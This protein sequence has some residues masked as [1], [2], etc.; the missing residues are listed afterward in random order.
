MK[1]G[2]MCGCNQGR[3]PCTC[4]GAATE[5]CADVYT[6]KAVEVFHA[7]ISQVTEAQRRAAKSVY[8]ALYFP[9]SGTH[10]AR[11]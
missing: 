3:L 2:T 7:P 6:K 8:Y 11:S 10:T 4:K 1:T 5:D 9:G